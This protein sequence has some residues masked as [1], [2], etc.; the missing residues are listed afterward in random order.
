MHSAY[1]IKDLGDAKFY[2]GFGI[3]RNEKDIFLIQQKFISDLLQSADLL[4]RK[5]FSVPIDTNLKP[6]DD[7]RSGDL[8]FDY[9]LYKQLVGKLLYLTSS[10]PNLSYSVQVLSQFSHASRE[11]HFKAVIRVL[12]NLK[13][14]IAHGLF[15]PAS[16]SFKITAYSDS[17]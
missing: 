12:R 6:Y 5:P 3:F 8:I 13:C 2:L 16:N 14:T 9:S 10:R 4:D 15:F 11:K 7:S 17:D 1:T